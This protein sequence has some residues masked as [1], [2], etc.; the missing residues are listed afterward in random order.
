M[1]L[2]L[3]EVLVRCRVGEADLNRWIERDWVRPVRQE[4]GWCFAD[5]DVA[6]IELIVDLVHDLA[7]DPEA[8]DV[9]L[10]LID[11][12]YALRRSLRAMTRAMEVLPEESR[13]RVLERLTERPEE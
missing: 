10:P 5:Q 4:G 11:Q 3:E 9:I 6:R 1:M 12:V 7:I 2:V 13:R 8:L